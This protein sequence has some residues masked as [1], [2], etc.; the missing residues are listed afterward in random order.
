MK[1]LNKNLIL[2]Y[3]ILC[4]YMSFSAQM[5]TALQAQINRIRQP[6]DTLPQSERGTELS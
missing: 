4:I 3:N 2:C 6:T 5:Q 1:V